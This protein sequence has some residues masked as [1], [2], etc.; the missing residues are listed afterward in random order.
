MYQKGKEYKKLKNEKIIGVKPLTG[1]DWK[2]NTISRRVM[3][4]SCFIRLIAPQTYFQESKNSNAIVKCIVIKVNPPI[5]ACH[6]LKVKRVFPFWCSSLKKPSNKSRS[7]DLKDLFYIYSF[8]DNGL[9]W[10]VS[11]NRTNEIL[12][13]YILHEQNKKDNVI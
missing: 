2:K 4:V 6:F 12:V 5:K 7:S 1:F 8:L 9:L 3:K 11:L 10:F 13:F